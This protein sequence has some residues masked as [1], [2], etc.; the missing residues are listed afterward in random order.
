[1]P[2]VTAPKRRLSYDA[3]QALTPR[4]LEILDA[5]ED[6]VLQGGFAD[7]TMAEIAK[8]MGCSLRT[9]Y[10]IA[11]SKDELVLAILDR[12]LHRIGREAV[13]ALES[14]ETALARLHAY[15]RATNLAVQPT[16]A[17]FSRDFSTVPGARQLNEAHTDY[18]VAITQALLNE[19]ME[20]GQIGPVNTAALAILLGRLGN[21]FARAEMTDVVCGSPQKTADAAAEIII[22]GLRTTRPD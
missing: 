2:T 7:V 19:A 3:E 18:I 21:E 11:P 12:R 15:L 8:R 1:M 4:Q 9:L 14:D 6:W 5:L 22:A 16:T 13:R 20:E 17:A 10:G